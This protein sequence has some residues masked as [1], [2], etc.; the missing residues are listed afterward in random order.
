MNAQ[1]DTAFKE[2]LTPTQISRLDFE[3]ARADKTRLQA[4]LAEVELTRIVNELIPRQDVIAAWRNVEAAIRAKIL[5]LTPKIA[6]VCAALDN[7]AD[8]K[9]AVDPMIRDA[10]NDLADYRPEID[11]SNSLLS[12]QKEPEPE[13]VKK[14][15]KMG[16]PKNGNFNK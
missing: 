4:E 2:V 8:I 3:R 16:R 6:A 9:R 13:E 12:D 10:L 15:K 7:P 1:T 5:G 14:P 11:V